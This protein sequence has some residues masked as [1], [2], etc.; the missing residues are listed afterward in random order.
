MFRGMRTFFIVWA[1]QLVST[2]G[3]RITGFAL[4]VWIYETT[5]SVTLFAANML[6]LTL[7]SIALAPLAGLL[8]DRW[9]RRHVML[10]AD[11]G[12]ALAT[13]GVWLLNAA[14]ILAV[15][16][17]YVATAFLAGFSTLQ[18]PA[19][20]AATTM[21][22]PKDQLG[23]AG[24][25]VQIGNAASELVAPAVAGALY[26]LSGLRTTLLLDLGTFI[27]AVATLVAVRFPPPPK[28][29][30]QDTEEKSFRDDLLYGWRYL[31][32]RPGLLGLV[33]MFAVM[34]FTASAA[35][36]VLTPML[37]D[38]T[39]PDVLG[40]IGSTAGIGMVLGT[41]VMSLWGGPKRRI[42]AIYV[43]EFLAG[44][45]MML[46]GLTPLIPLIVI[47]NF[48][49]LFLNPIT[50]GNSQALW[51]SK[52]AADVQGRVF[53]VRRMIAE[54]IT[55]IAL[56]IAAPLAERVFE[57]LMETGGPLADTFIGDVVGTGPGRGIGLMFIVMGGLYTL[58][59]VGGALYPR[60]RRVEIELPDSLPGTENAPAESSAD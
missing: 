43:G 55:P 46:I 27:V 34:N 38:L 35:F 49:F 36:V 11:G 51:Q 2:I 59:S 1:G 9:D 58:A 40:I 60:L 8:A 16:H 45:F 24:G 31:L 37:L 33:M 52:V 28:V 10:L 48:L 26:V 3:S 7:P 42:Y 17:I 41:V 54:A 30:E 6:A 13:L 14:G 57:P 32:A 15:W 50:N 56:I 20:G 4:G 23:R 19:Y 5:G 12:A 53:A 25:L 39:T 47:G 44:L 29:A 21:L 18:W 22:V